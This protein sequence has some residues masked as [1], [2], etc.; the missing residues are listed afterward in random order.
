MVLTAIVNM[1]LGS[2]FVSGYRAMFF[3]SSFVETV[4]RFFSA[5][6]IAMFTP[7]RELW[8]LV[9]KSCK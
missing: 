8:E 1:H 2:D 3:P 5:G 4:S 6:K 7:F 9:S